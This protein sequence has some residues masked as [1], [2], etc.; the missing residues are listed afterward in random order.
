MPCPNNL[1]RKLVV[2]TE[3]VVA[4]AYD[5]EGWHTGSDDSWHP[6]EGIGC[7]WEWGHIYRRRRRKALHWAQLTLRH[8]NAMAW[9]TSILVS[10]TLLLHS[11]AYILES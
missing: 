3:C 5:D 9:P 8:N 4:L 11:P 6:E 7:V 10:V 1:V 2:G